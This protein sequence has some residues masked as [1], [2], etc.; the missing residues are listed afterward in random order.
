MGRSN[1]GG[2]TE[3]AADGAGCGLCVREGEPVGGGRQGEGGVYGGVGKNRSIVATESPDALSPN[4]TDSGHEVVEPPGSPFGVFRLAYRQ[5]P[6][7]PLPIL[8]RT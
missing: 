7:R 4:R 8:S 2:A 1:P 6:P 5:Q 3:A